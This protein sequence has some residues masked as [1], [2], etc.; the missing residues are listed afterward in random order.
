MFSLK[1]ILNR[2][3]INTH[4]LLFKFLERNTKAL[5]MRKCDLLDETIKKLISGENEKFHYGDIEIKE[6]SL[7]YLL[8]IFTIERIVFIKKILLKKEQGIIVD[9]GDSNGIFLRSCGHSGISVNISDP[10]VHSL[11]GKGMETIQADIEHLPFKTGSIQM[12]FLFETLEHVQN[13]I[14][15]LKEIGRISDNLIL[16]VPYVTHTHTYPIN[17][18][19]GRPIH[20]HH[21]FE[22]NK[23]DLE[24]IISHTPFKVCRE[25]TAVVI[26]EN[27]GLSDRIILFLWKIFFEKDMF[28]GCF[29]RFLILQLKRER[30]NED[31]SAFF[32][33]A[34][35]WKGY[36]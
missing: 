4:V 10:V 28:C 3:G 24:T 34:K 33:K 30:K 20:Q 16:S 7:E 21:I 8:K 25:H 26:D 2:C 31:G 5:L 17:Y 32:Q 36:R 22:F 15:L 1:S 6:K 9:L 23:E 11:R 14:S 12:V 35:S 29:R 27:G 18:D 13:P 19:L